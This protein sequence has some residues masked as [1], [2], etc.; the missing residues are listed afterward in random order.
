MPVHPASLPRGRCGAVQSLKNGASVRWSRLIER[1]FMHLLEADPSVQSYEPHP[2]KVPILGG[3][4]V[5][6]HTIAFKVVAQTGTVFV[7]LADARFRTE[8][9]EAAETW[10]HEH[11]FAYRAVTKS[12][13]YA[14]P[15]FD[16]ARMLL[17]ARGTEVPDHLALALTGL[18]QRGARPL[19]DVEAA[20]LD[21]DHPRMHVFALALRGLVRLD[22]SA[23]L[24]GGTM[25]SL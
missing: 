25:V 5:R 4:R 22:M 23:P 18:L 17:D 24:S 2:V 13:V 12:E 3:L 16:N 20:L 11:G 21:V 8:Q 6:Q 1:D 10:C 14:Q 15:R 19:A 9:A 7:D